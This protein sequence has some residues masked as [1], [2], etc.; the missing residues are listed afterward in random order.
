VSHE[1]RPPF[2]LLP[3]LVSLD[4]P[5]VAI[6]WLWMFRKT[7]RAE[8]LPGAAY[9]A[10]GLAVWSIYIFDRLFDASLRAGTPEL[11]QDR[12]RF[13]IRHKKAFVAAGTAAGLAAV[14]TVLVALPV[15]LL[16]Y[17]LFGGVLVVGFFAVSLFS[18]YREEEIPYL[19]NILAGAAFAYGTAM[20][21]HVYLP[22]MDGFT[23]IR[24][25]DVLLTREAACFAVLCIMN[26]T[27]IDLWERSQ[28]NHDDEL[29][30]SNT[31]ALTLPLTLLGAMALLFAVQADKEIM[32]PAEI[33]EGG[34]DQA[35]IIRAFYYGVLVST[36]LLLALNHQRE[37]FPVRSLRALV[38]LALLVAVAVFAVL[39]R[40]HS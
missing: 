40:K 5:I 25:V 15:Q 4:A 19:K 22:G 38:D 37:K 33:P 13:H 14:V 30:A 18:D 23:G 16:T 3:N 24:F 11:L 7:W 20:I 9:L 31:I 34:Y 2:W 21:A 35:I 32:R 17:I 39:I 6:S 26:I 28:R 27:A 29:Q 1:R 12:H 36:G 10:L 8:Y